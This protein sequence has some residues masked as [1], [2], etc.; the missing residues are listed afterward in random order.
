MRL[1]HHTHPRPSRARRSARGLLCAAVTAA[2]VVGAGGAAADPTPAPTAASCSRWTALLVPG[3]WET[4]P[5]ADPTRPVGM[6][7]PVAQGLTAHYGS[8]IDVRTL[9][10]TAPYTT[11]QTAGAQA[12]T[13]T[14]A[15]LCSGTRVVLAGYSQGAD[16]V[17]DLAT[18]IGNQA[19][20]IPASRVVAIGLVSDPHRDRPPPSS[21]TPCPA[22]ASPDRAPRTSA[23]SPTVS[24]RC[25]PRVTS[26]ARP[27]RRHRLPWPRWAAP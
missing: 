4:T 18:A 20:P 1:H 6:L 26:T 21:G 3:T 19:G 11:S 7:T 24:A 16:I 8:D 13:A 14:L 12:L 22:R 9:A 10:Y 17:G 5:A 23:P 27:R 2:T 15:G 25:V